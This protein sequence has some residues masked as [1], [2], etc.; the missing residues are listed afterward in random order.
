MDRGDRQQRPPR[1]PRKEV[2]P[3]AADELRLKDAAI[4][5]GGLN[6]DD[7]IEAEAAVDL[8]LAGVEEG[9]AGAVDGE[10][11][12]RRRRRGGRNRNRRER[13]TTEGGESV[14][15]AADLEAAED[16]S[17]AGDTGVEEEEAPRVAARSEAPSIALP[18][19]K[20]EQAS[21][22]A[23][24][25]VPAAETSSTVASEADAVSSEA[26]TV[27]TFTEADTAP[28][29]AEAS[30]VPAEVAAPEVSA[31]SE[32][33]A[34][35]ADTPVAPVAASPAPAAPAEPAPVP[36][37]TSPVEP[38]APV[39][40]AAP[41]EAAAPAKAAAPVVPSVTSAPMPVADLRDM[42][43]TAGLTLATTD[44]E[45]LRAAEEAAASIPPAP[46]SVRERKPAPTIANEPLVQVETRP[47][48]NSAGM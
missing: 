42:L 48:G 13:E 29:F 33:P 46:R 47:G 5:A 4:A 8:E 41:V 43:S 37:S 27:R 44:P 14:Q 28:S 7:L 10:Q 38:V 26:L 36:A 6:P 34:P 17:E 9:T 20:P 12:R 25:E 21:A 3:E 35:Q 18:S 31:V 39:T 16:M 30:A 2:V 22:K 32:I 24:W 40:V 15:S 11:P 19:V 1:E 45:K 23:W